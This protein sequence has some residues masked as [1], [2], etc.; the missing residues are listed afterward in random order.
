M[1]RLPRIINYFIILTPLV[2][3]EEFLTCDIRPY[4]SRVKITLPA[5]YLL[6]IVLYFVQRFA[7]TNY[8][9]TSIIFGCIGWFTEFVVNGLMYILPIP[10]T[11]LF[12]VL[13]VLIY[14]VLALMPTY[15]LEKTLPH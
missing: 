3:V 15:Y 4:L 9:T 1:S 12:S 2:L 8:R 6:F 5:F 14:A 11:V 7:K 13:V 10:T